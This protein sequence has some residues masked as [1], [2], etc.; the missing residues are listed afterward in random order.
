MNQCVAAARASIGDGAEA[1]RTLHGLLALAPH[2]CTSWISLI[3]VRRQSSPQCTEV[4]VHHL[5]RPDAGPS[6]APGAKRQRPWTGRVLTMQNSV[7]NIVQLQSTEFVQLLTGIQSRLYSLSICTLIADGA[8]AL[9]VLQEANV[10][11]WEKAHEYDP[12]RPFA[13]W[14]YRIAYLQVLAYRKRCVRRP[15][16]VRR[17]ARARDCRGVPSSRMK[18][19]AFWLEALA[20]S[21]WISCRCPDASC[22]I[23]DMVMASRST[24]SPDVCASRRTWCQQVYTDFER[25]SWRALNPGWRPDERDDRMIDRDDQIESLLDAVIDGQCDADQLRKFESLIHDPAIRTAYLR[26]MRTHALLQWRHGRLGPRPERNEPRN[27]RHWGLCGLRRGSIAVLL[28]I[29]IGAT[30]VVS[31]VMWH[32]ARSGGVASLVEAR[33]VVWGKGQPPIGVNAR[34]GPGDIRL[35]SGDAH[36]RL[37]SRCEGRAGRAPP[38]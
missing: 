32:D 35:A 7:Q 12:T 10:V 15:A 30:V 16:R 38:T 34:V 25:R 11:L 37:R 6:G 21:A 23:V 22:S 8:G 29:G 20:G 14:A 19:M 3:G 36:A 24:R 1:G 27:V 18:T 4:E 5:R 2:S 31:R 17:N 26:Q 33:N 13:P 28:L 9:D